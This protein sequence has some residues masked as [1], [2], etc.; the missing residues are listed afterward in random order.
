MKKL[1]TGII[2]LL[3]IIIFLL[4]YCNC[5]KKCKHTDKTSNSFCKTGECDQFNGEEPPGMINYILAERMSDDY[6]SD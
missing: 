3:L 2:I 5:K 1:L 6:G 4:L